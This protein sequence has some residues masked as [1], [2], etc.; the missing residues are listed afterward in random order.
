MFNIAD[1]ETVKRGEVVDVYFTRTRQI[2]Q[3]QGLDARIRAEF[4]AKGLPLDWDWAVLAG[5]DEV[6]HLAGDLEVNIR[7]MPE[8][9]VFH[10]FQPIMEIE[11]PYLA[12]GHLETAILGLLCV[13]WIVR[14]RQKMV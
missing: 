7:V 2:L 4:T 8:G 13:E 3:A 14:K 1:F 5:L 9:T 12:F 6:H 11:G 10:S